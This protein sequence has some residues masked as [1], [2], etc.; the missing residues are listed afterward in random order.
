[1]KS[2][3]VVS[4]PEWLV[5][6]RALLV[7]EKEFTRLRDELSSARRA[8]PWERVD[9]VYEFQ[10]ADGIRDLGSLFDGCSQL[11]VYHFMLGPDWEAGCKSCSFWADNFDGIDIHLA[12]RDVTLL[13]ISQAPLPRIEAY[14]RRM[15]WRFRWV[16]SFGSDFNFDY[17]V[18]FRPEQIATGTV[19][20][21]YEQ[22]TNSM[23]ELAGISAFCRDPAGTVYHTYSCYSRGL[24]MLNGAYH[25]LDLVPKGRDEDELPSTMAWLRRRDEY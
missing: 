17:Q 4:P 1:M 3:T 10:T 12:H 5:A 22:R 21:N 19:M 18:S 20:H 14:R 2:H 25:F 24:D 23:T 11:V 16:S 15:G 9:K 7:K 8:L 13:A 6:R